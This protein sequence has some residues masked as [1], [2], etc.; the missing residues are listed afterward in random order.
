MTA[1]I[2]MA[3]CEP[4]SPLRRLRIACVISS[5]RGGGAELVMS[6][7]ANQLNA[8]GHTVAIYTFSS[9]ETDRYP[10][11][12]SVY[13]CSLGHERQSRHALDRMRNTAG[14][15]R[16]LVSSLAEWRPDVVVSFME[17]TNVLVLLANQRLRYPIVISERTDPRLHRI[18]RVTA[19]LRYALYG[20]ADALVV[21]T[22]SIK[23]WAQSLPF[24]APTYVISNPV[25]PHVVVDDPEADAAGQYILAVGRLS[26]EKGF[27]SLLRA[28]A[29]LRAAEPGLKLVILGE[30]R[31]RAKLEALRAELKLD[32]SVLLPGHR[33]STSWLNRAVM[34]VLSS[35]YEGFPN[36][37]AEAMAAGLP[38]V[39]TRCCGPEEMIQD[40]QDGFL[41]PVDDIDA[42]VARMRRLLSD[43]PLRE[44]LGARARQVA[45][46]RFAPE[47]IWNEWQNVI[48]QAIV[49]RGLRSGEHAR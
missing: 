24:R 39:A 36:A 33:P 23:S 2:P 45:E 11:L 19:A 43:K 46:T 4:Q 7:L 26:H 38:V 27:D 15:I 13:R 25:R 20:T 28:F 41:V 1:E 9:P 14:R 34:F 12:P 35:R 10:L 8:N 44:L 30:G 18:D 22:R 17:I 49:N 6:G 3:N 40:G 37:L 47:L 29:V 16:T 48:D 32:D 42:M 21:Q 5:L 31:D